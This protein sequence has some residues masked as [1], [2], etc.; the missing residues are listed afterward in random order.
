M[1]LRQRIRSGRWPCCAV[2]VVGLVCLNLA[3]PALAGKDLSA[4]AYW[5][6]GLNL[7]VKHIEVADLNDD[8]VPDVIAGEYSS[9]YYGTPSLVFAIDGYT[10]D[11]LWTYQLQDGVRS[12]TIGDLNNDGVADVVAGAS[13]DPGDTPDGRIHGINGIDGSQLWTFYIGSTIDDVC[14]GDFN[15]DE[16]PDV[17]AASWDD[18]VYAVNGFTGTQIW[19]R[20]IGSIFINAVSAADVNDDGIDD[21]AYANEYLTGY[22]NYNGVL[23]GTDGI[24]IWEHTAAFSF[25]EALMADIDEDGE[26][27]A[28]FGTQHD[29]DHY[30]IHVHDGLTGSIEWTYNLGSVT[31][32]NAEIIL[33]ALDI[34]DNGSLEL[35]AGNV[36]LRMEL[37]VFEGGSNSPLWISELLAG[38]PRDAAVGDV[39][40]NATMNVVVATGDRVQV[41]EAADGTKVW[42]YAVA[43]NIRNVDVGD[44]D[45]N[46]FADVAA[47]GGAEHTGWPPE[48]GKTV[49]ALRTVESPLLWEYEFGEYGNDLAIGNFNGDEYMDV[50]TVASIG[51]NAVAVDGRTGEHLWTWAGTANLYSATCGDFNGDDVDDA[52]VGGYDE[53][54]TAINGSDGSTL[55][56]FTDPTQQIYRKCLVATDLND[57][58]MIDVVAG[59]DNGSVYAINGLTGTTIW[60]YPAGAAINEVTLAQMNNSGPLDA[61]AAVGSGTSGNKIVVIDGFDGSLLW[62]H[63]LGSGVEHV[64]AGDVN[65][66]FVPD[67]AAGISN[68]VV[69]ID[70]QMRG[71]LWTTYLSVATNTNGMTAGDLNDDKAIDIIVPG[72]S[73]D[74]KV[75]ALSGI[76]GSELW[77]FQ[78]GGEVNC[79]LVDDV[80]GD[81]WPEVVAGSDD[82]IVY[83]LNHETGAEEWSYS[84]ADDVMQVGV[85]DIGGDGRPCIALATFG[86]NG[87]AYAFRSLAPLITYMCGDLNDDDVVNLLDIVFLIN[88]KYKNGP[89]PEPLESADVNGDGVVN[90]LDIVYLV[91]YKYKGGPEPNC[92]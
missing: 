21:V 24:E 41:L 80:D 50:V 76:D 65:G 68:R 56:Q 19:R 53:I 7:D 64:V 27:E 39:D 66:D 25:I 61:I 46:G 57:D 83:V 1:K 86:S 23:N 63:D 52:A 48:P 84:T 9:D 75:H 74:M 10:G 17:A 67:V 12:M 16:Y 20:Y 30:E 44:F 40:A 59:C 43:G 3:P 89:A 5:T 37:V 85:G 33:Q 45:D 81:F 55:W 2:L 22:D 79:V 6:Y 29:D 35:V 77:A 26:V 72:A 28:I 54:V 78:T 91:N 71:E 51:D 36:Y 69:M 58:D 32:I 15:G 38:Y 87:I 11:T 88:Y 47:G 82:Q 34:D 42:Y 90:L 4:E 70:G 8:K 18:Y 31:G 92:Q 73:A 14:I 60:I 49:W 62:D 13:N